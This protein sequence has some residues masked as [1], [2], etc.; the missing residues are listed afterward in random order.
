M[1]SSYDAAVIGSGGGPEGFAPLRRP[2][3]GDG[4]R[5]HARPARLIGRRARAGAV[6]RRGVNGMAGFVAAKSVLAARR[7]VVGTA[8]GGAGGALRTARAALSRAQPR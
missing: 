5:R 1:P 6:P 8:T 4:R 3:P 7:G 2:P